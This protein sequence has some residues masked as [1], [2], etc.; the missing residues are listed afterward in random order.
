[1]KENKSHQIKKPVKIGIV[2]DHQLFRKSI[3]LLAAS[4]EGVEVVLQA[5]SGKELFDM[6][7][8][9][10]LDLL[11]LDIEM[12]VM[13]GFQACLLLRERY[14]EIKILIVSQIHTRESIHKVMDLGAHGFLS[15]NA[16]PEQLEQAIA[17]I[18]EEGIY[19]EQD[20]STVIKEAIIWENKKPLP[21]LSSLLKI[22][23]REMEV[24]RLA[25]YEKSN[26]EIA[27]ALNISVRTVEVHRK[28]IIKRTESKNFIG[29]ILYA[30]RHGLILPEN[31]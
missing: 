13:N 15:K 6:L 20:F 1:M 29:V 14:P 11:L 18:H 22:S 19:F 21:L 2:D 5:E 31:L 30:I 10:H 4:F 3:A 24:I 17:R 7:P 28:R 27:D 12:P 25:C 23:H 26:I 9:T 16:G 8:T